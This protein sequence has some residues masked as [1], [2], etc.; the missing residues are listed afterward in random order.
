MIEMEVEKNIELEKTTKA[1]RQ[2]GLS[3]H[4]SNAYAT[5]VI[6]GLM[7]PREISDVTDIPYTRLYSVLKDL[8]RK[9]WVESQP[10]RPIVYKAVRPKYAV[11]NAIQ[12]ILKELQK[13]EEIVTQNLE[14]I[15]SKTLPVGRQV[16]VV[17][18][19]INV[20]KKI[21]EMLDNARET[22]KI[23]TPFIQV[24]KQEDSKFESIRQKLLSYRV[25]TQ[26]IAR[27]I[28]ESE[29]DADLIPEH[30]QIRLHEG[31]HSW[32]VIVDGNEILHSSSPYVEKMD[33]SEILGIWTNDQNIIST[34]ENMYDFFWNEA[35][36][37]G[38]DKI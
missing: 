14:N 2:F 17:K 15:Y 12:E 6:K 11:R 21:L 20:I 31:F 8:E 38:S 24:G 25:R 9:G 18:G 35:R 7:S 34:L 28:T 1:L 4:E 16:W 5:L 26:I 3:E 19:K 27:M 22:V 33:L 10:G 36:P 23:A 13:A 30:I 37:I 32:M 29:Y